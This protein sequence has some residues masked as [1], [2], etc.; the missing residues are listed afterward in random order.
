MPPRAG[1]KGGGSASLPAYLLGSSPRHDGD[2]G[3]RNVVFFALC[4]MLLVRKSCVVCK[5]LWGS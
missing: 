4:I 5:C 3:W 1:E 2:F